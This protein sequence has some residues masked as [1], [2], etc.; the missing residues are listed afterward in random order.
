MGEPMNGRRNKPN[1]ETFTNALPSSTDI[2]KMLECAKNNALRD[3][4]AL[5]I[6]FEEDN[7]DNL[8][9]ESVQKRAQKVLE[10]NSIK[11]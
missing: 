4:S 8:N 7:S 1:T 9:E 6:S 11:R 3:L 10:N 2:I 5:G